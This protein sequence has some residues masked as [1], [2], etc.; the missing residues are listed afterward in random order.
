MS[1][2]MIYMGCA[3]VEDATQHISRTNNDDR[4]YVVLLTRPLSDPSV[5]PIVLPRE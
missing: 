3:C 2:N 1:N 4:V 5:N